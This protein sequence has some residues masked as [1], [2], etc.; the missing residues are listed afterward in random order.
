VLPVGPKPVRAL[1]ASHKQSQDQDKAAPN[2]PN[3]T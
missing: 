3:P 1:P 2:L